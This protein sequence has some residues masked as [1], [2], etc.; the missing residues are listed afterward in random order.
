MTPHR[1]MGEQHLIASR[2]NDASFSHW[3][4]RRCLVASSP[5]GRTKRCLVPTLGDEAAPHPRTERRRGTSF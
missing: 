2:E 1:L 4:M 3:K 5:H